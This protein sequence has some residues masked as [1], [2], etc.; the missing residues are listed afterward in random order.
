MDNSTPTHARYF[1]DHNNARH[2]L[3]QHGHNPKYVPTWGW[4]IWDGKRWQ[5]DRSNLITSL[6]RETILTSLGTL[7]PVTYGNILP[8]IMLCSPPPHLNTPSRLNPLS[9]IPIPS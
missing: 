6:A 1:I 9:S 2:L 4:L 5:R 7:P 8:R 3:E